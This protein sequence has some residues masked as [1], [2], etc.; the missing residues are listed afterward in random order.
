MKT[1]G[2]FLTPCEPRSSQP[3]TLSDGKTS[4]NFQ[5]K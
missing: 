5:A 1:L 4:I 2:K 3:S